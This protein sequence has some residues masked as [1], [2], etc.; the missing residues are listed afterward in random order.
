MLI[1]SYQLTQL[2][3]IVRR[4]QQFVR[5]QYMNSDLT[6]DMLAEELQI[7]AI[8]YNQYRRRN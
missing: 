8:Y 5:E 6:L 4:G 3:P 1:T 2:S 7:S